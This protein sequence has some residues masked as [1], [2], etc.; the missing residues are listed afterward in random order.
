MLPATV[1]GLER[2]KENCCFYK[3]K[4]FYP[5]PACS[6]KSLTSHYR[7]SQWT[8]T[9]ELRPR[10]KVLDWG[11]GYELSVLNN[12]D[13][14]KKKQLSFLISKLKKIRGGLNLKENR[15]DLGVLLLGQRAFFRTWT[16]QQAHPLGCPQRPDVPKEEA[17]G[18]SVIYFFSAWQ[19]SSGRP[20]VRPSC[21]VWHFRR[22]CLSIRMQKDPDRGWNVTYVPLTLACVIPSS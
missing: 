1:P 22:W 17:R 15:E 10:G 11:T 12:H 7:V 5:I 3:M 21:E 20:N 2:W 8:Q 18:G 4:P 19:I 14:K 16:G 9:G 6:F 13:L